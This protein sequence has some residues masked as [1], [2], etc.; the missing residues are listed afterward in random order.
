MVIYTTTEKETNKVEQIEI[1]LINAINKT[2]ECHQISEETAETIKNEIEKIKKNSNNINQFENAI[3]SYFRT[4]YE[5]KTVKKITGRKIKCELKKQYPVPEQNN[6]FIKSIEEI[7]KKRIVITKISIQTSK[8]NAEI[9][10]RE[11]K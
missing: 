6:N 7:F 9:F 5:N 2:L 8:G 10:K 11:Y 1:R 4:L 3:I